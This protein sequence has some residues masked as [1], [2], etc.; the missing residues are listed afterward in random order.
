MAAVIHITTAWNVRLILRLFTQI[1]RMLGVNGVQMIMK[2]ALRQ[3]RNNQGW[4]H[5]EAEG[6]TKYH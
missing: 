1:E 2:K 4:K 3:P 5:P 6:Y